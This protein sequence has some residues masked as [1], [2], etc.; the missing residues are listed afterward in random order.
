MGSNEK[1]IEKFNSHVAQSYGRYPLAMKRDRA[2][3][4]LTKAVRNILISEAE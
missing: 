3:D 4:A 1:T 2:D